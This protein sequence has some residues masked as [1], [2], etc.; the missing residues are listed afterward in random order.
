[1]DRIKYHG[2]PR[3][4]YNKFITVGKVLL[5]TKSWVQGSDHLELHKNDKKQHRNTKHPDMLQRI[6]DYQDYSHSIHSAWI[7]TKK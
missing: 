7:R 6:E 2:E 5:I 3:C 1:M 4:Q